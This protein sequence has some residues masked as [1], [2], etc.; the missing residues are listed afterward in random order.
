VL[1]LLLARA[2]AGGPRTRLPLPWRAAGRLNACRHPRRLAN[3]QIVERASEVGGGKRV[4]R[5]RDL[6]GGKIVERVS[7]W[8]GCEG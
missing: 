3:E 1:K 2:R 4:E 5:A 8:W 6:G 7:E